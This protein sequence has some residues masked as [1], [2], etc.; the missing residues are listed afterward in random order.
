[1][2]ITGSFPTTQA[3]CPGGRSDTSPGPNSA[4]APSSITTCRRPATWYFR[5]GASYAIRLPIC[6][7][8]LLD[9]PRPSCYTPCLAS[10]RTVVAGTTLRLESVWQGAGLFNYAPGRTTISCRAGQWRAWAEVLYPATRSRHGVNRLGAPSGLLRP[11]FV[12][13][14]R[15]RMAGSFF[16]FLCNP[17]AFLGRTGFIRRGKATDEPQTVQNP[18]HF[19]LART[20]A[21]PIETCEASSRHQGEGQSLN[22]RAASRKLAKR[23]AGQ[24]GSGTL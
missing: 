21:P 1:M 6:L 3:S 12:P 18:A 9:W 4:S 8:I 14:V 16:H 10:R 22:A 2:T 19:R 7:P 15:A 20:L 17:D 23:L 13:G 24:P 11:Q 5:F